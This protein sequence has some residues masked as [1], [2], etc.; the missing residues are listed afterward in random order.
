ML[1]IQ[2]L[3][4]QF[5]DSIMK[6]LTVILLYFLS[7]PF[8]LSQ[9]EQHS[10]EITIFNATKKHCYV[11]TRLVDH[12]IFIPE[13]REARIDYDKKN[14]K[15]I[16]SGVV[17]MGLYP[18]EGVEIYLC[19]KLKHF[20]RNTEIWDSK[21]KIVKKIGSNNI[22]YYTLDGDNQHVSLRNNTKNSE[23]FWKEIEILKKNHTVW[24]DTVGIFNVSFK[25]DE[26]P[27]F[28]VLSQKK[29]QY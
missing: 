1:I 4:L 10:Y 3:Y 18:I 15:I 5:Q 28:G 29:G 11:N 26:Y 17:Y 22:S 2:K 25:E 14:N 6:L 9:N 8:L 27:F 16:I 13:P 23:Q 7:F 12:S 21:F 20:G 24:N 19:R